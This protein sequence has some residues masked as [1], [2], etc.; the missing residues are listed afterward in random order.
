MR[1]SGDEYDLNLPSS[2]NKEV[3][4][5]SKKLES[6][7][8]NSSSSESDNEEFKTDAVFSF[9]EQIPTLSNPPK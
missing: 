6:I 9:L 2:K 4:D 7:L 3:D 5:F 1:H 8:D